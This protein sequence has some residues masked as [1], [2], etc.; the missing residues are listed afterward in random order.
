MSKVRPLFAAGLLAALAAPALVFPTT[1]HAQECANA[2]LTKAIK[3]VTGRAPK[4]SGTAGECNPEMY[5]LI[6]VD[7]KAPSYDEIKEKVQALLGKDANAPTPAQPPK[8]IT[9]RGPSDERCFGAVGSKCD[10]APR[11]GRSGNT[12]WVSVGSILHDN[13]C[14]AN[15]GGKMCS[16][17]ASEF[18]HNGK[19]VKEWDKAF[20][21]T[22]TDS[23]HWQAT[24]DPNA[25]PDLTW[26]SARRSRFQDGSSY[27]GYETRATIGLSAPRG[28]ALD[29]GDVAFCASQRAR[30]YNVWGTPKRWIVCE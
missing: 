28:T 18:R 25:V 14:L 24:F 8:K 20:W 17:L 27:N 22:F 5:Q 30:E 19:C 10:G 26:V 13:C 3:E 4:G 12:L 9:T 16:G 29:P 21:N 15:P 1:T 7:G 23:R 6:A 11:A 2:E